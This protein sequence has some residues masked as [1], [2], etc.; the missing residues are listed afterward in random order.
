MT[1]ESFM[2]SSVAFFK[3]DPLIHRK[4]ISR[5]E[6]YFSSEPVNPLVKKIDKEEESKKFIRW[7]KLIP[8][9][10][11]IGV[12]A[13]F[14]PHF[15]LGC[16]IAAGVLAINIIMAAVISAFV[17][18]KMKKEYLEQ[19]KNKQLL[20][21]LGAPI[22]EELIF[23]GAMLQLS[24]L[25]IGF[26]FPPALILPFLNTGLSIAAA[27]AIFITT[28]IFG[29]AHA[30]NAEKNNF[31]QVATTFLGGLAFGFLAIQFGLLVAI[32][33]HVL[34]NTVASLFLNLSAPSD[35]EKKEEAG[36]YE[37]LRPKMA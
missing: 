29:L 1:V 19:L 28:V 14:L 7:L 18:S 11:L 31:A 37:V 22:L 3:S 23:R 12:G 21:T 15:A 5:S 30:S 25:L 9:V 24:L 33:A 17:K 34:N 36:E 35:E 6:Q 27:T 10:A 32:G 13:A 4:K 8:A 20:V 16:A 2:A 26:A